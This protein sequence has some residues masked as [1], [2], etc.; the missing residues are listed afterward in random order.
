MSELPDPVLI[1]K[2]TTI[3][4]FLYWSVRGWVRMIRFV[5]RLERTA[6]A[7]G[8]AKGEVRRQVKRVA[9]CATIGD[10]LNALLLCFIVWLWIAPKF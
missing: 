8:L 3:A 7:S 5:K 6:S 1:C 9:L 4:L 2:A 10:P